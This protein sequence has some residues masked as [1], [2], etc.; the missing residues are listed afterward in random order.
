M[1]GHSHW[2]NIQ[3]KK[4]AA[5][6]KRG[7]LFSK[8]ARNIMVAARNGGGDIA[9]NLRL[10]YAIDK[11]R[12]VSMPKDTIERS[13]KK[14]TGD[15]EGV[16]FEE[17]QYEGFGPGSAGVAIVCDVLTDKRT[18]TYGE[19][20]TIFEKSGGTLGQPGSVAYMFDRKG[21]FT[22]KAAGTSEE[23]LMDLVLE[24]GADDL[25][26]DGDHF[27]IICEPTAFNEVSAALE[28]AGIHPESADL[29]MIP[30]MTA[31]ADTETGQRILRL[32]DTLDDN[33]DVQ[34]VYTNLNITE[35]MAAGV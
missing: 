10:R 24:A 1:A 30:S 35:E 12:S 15:L 27:E 9:M 32:M 6:K 20:R 2:N 21:L 34:A 25:S 28:K 26:R 8:L 23:L 29:S 13:I 31:D 18:R 14:G 3:H 19:I 16:V 4:G 22:V 33:D 17:L 11:A 5:D 7:V